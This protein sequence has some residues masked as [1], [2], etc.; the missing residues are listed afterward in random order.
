[1]GYI[2]A[3]LM[4]AGA[5]KG[6]IVACDATFIKVYSKR[7]P[8]DNSRAMAILMLGLEGLRKPTSSATSFT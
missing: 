2:L 5:I 7:D 8:E 6:E 1:M 4:D 3:R